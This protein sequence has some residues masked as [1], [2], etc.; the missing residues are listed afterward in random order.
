MMDEK[1]IKDYHKLVNKLE[2][3]AKVKGIKKSNKYN[4]MQGKQITDHET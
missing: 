2:K 3:Q 1:D 4:Y